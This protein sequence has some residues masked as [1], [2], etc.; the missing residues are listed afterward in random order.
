[1]SD[2]TNASTASTPYVLVVDDEEPN[3]LLM[4]EF[5]K[6]LGHEVEAVAS[7]DEALARV[8]ARTPDVVLLDVMMPGMNGF[9]VC[10]RLKEDPR[11][12]TV[13]V[14]IVSALSVREDRLEG[15]RSGADDF[16]N[17]PVDTQEVH[18]RMRNALRTKR[19][20]DENAAYQN[21]LEQRVEA[22]TKELQAAHERL[23]LQLRE[24]EGRDRLVRLQMSGPSFAQARQEAVQV[25][26]EVLGASHAAL[27]LPVE[28]AVFP[29]CVA[30]AGPQ[31]D[32]AAPVPELA[33]DD[34]VVRALQAGEAQRSEGA[35]AVQVCYGDDVLG[36]LR[37]EGLGADEDLL[38]VL[39]RL[40]RETAVVLA[41]ARVAAELEEGRIDLDS[42][43]DLE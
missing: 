40:G 1:M 23:Q 32:P 5:V 8:A 37:V 38:N 42:L 30:A 29:E 25:V 14:I 39:C 3:R 7:G 26:A 16:L 10:R 19:L 33:A 17:K 13:Q 35:A 12:A 43:L 36:A 11:T 28:G 9:E 21:E 20:F 34:P 4:T 6:V 2:E 18:L 31:V 41:A 22:K 27:Y 24:L 15:I